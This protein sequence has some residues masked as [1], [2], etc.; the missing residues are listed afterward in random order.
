MLSSYIRSCEGYKFRIGSNLP[1]KDNLRK[2]D[3][4]SAPKMSLIRTFHCIQEMRSTVLDMEGACNFERG[5][6]FGC[7]GFSFMSCLIFCLF[8]LPSSL[9]SFLILLL[10]FKNASYALVPSLDKYGV[11][12]KFEMLVLSLAPLCYNGVPSGVLFI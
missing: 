8:F 7:L 12:S 11:L 2:K 4:S 10:T 1:P 6:L 3:K 9:V 5:C